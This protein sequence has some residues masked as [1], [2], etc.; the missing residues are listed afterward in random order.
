MVFSKN[1]NRLK[2]RCRK[3]SKKDILLGQRILIFQSNY[4]QFKKKLKIN[5]HILKKENKVQET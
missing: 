5:V 4:L 2:T 3:K 1:L